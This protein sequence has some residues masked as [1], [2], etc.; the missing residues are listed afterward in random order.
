MQTLCPKEVD[1]PAYHFV[2]HKT[3]GFSSSSVIF[4]IHCI[5]WNHVGHFH[6]YGPW[7][8]LYN[9]LS[10]IVELHFH[11]FLPQRYLSNGLLSSPN[12][13]CMQMLRP[14]EVDIPSYH[15]GDQKI[16]GT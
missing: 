14:W 15:I 12:K 9:D 10:S 3:I 6:Y 13:D 8:D 5:Q 11:Y 4:I 7:R 16:F 1:V 2:V